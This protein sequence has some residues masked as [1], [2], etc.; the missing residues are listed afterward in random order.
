MITNY[1]FKI[2]PSKILYPEYPPLDLY[3]KKKV[4]GIIWTSEEYTWS[5][6]PGY[7][8][9]NMG[10]I[11]VGD[12]TDLGKGLTFYL[13]AR[14]YS[15]SDIATNPCYGILHDIPEDF[16]VGKTGSGGIN[17]CGSKVRHL[18]TVGIEDSLYADW[19]LIN[20]Y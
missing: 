19:T 20:V 3:V 1:K 12:Y 18:A 15:S 16:S 8:K 17:Y 7:T 5:C 14:P 13:M 11:N 4:T 6:L 10:S 2:V 9:E